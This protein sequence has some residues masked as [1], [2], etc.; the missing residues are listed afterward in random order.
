MKKEKT[1]GKK[2][3]VIAGTSEATDLIVH[4]SDRLQITAFVATPYGKTI[5]ESANCTV[6]VGRLDEKKFHIALSGFDIVVDASHPFAVEV[7]RNVKTV[8]EKLHIPYYRIGRPQE[9][10]DY[11]DITYVNSKE[12]AVHLLRQTT[13]NI[14][15]TTG[16]NTL[17]FYQMQIPDFSKRVWARVLDTDASREMT[18]ESKAHMVYAMPPFTVE[19][20]VRLIQQNQIDVIVSKNSGK[21]GGMHEKIT[22]AKMCKIPVICIHAPQEEYMTI[23]EV[24]KVLENDCNCLS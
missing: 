15:L 11:D 4:I 19:D 16:G 8:C 14:L 17:F 24:I 13:G 1:N 23:T 9:N 22:A 2:I 3:A 6:H 7:T 10:Y 18:K 12:E 20:T 21:R 5:L